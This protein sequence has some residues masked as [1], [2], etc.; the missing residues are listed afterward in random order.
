MSRSMSRLGAAMLIGSEAMVPFRYKDSVG[1]D[2]EGIGHTV[3]A[4]APDPA[5][6]PFGQEIPLEEV[7]RTFRRDLRKF[8]KRVNDAV[9]VSIEQHEFDAVTH[10]DFNTGGVHRARLT[11]E[12]NAGR[13]AAA[14]A[15]FGGWHRPPEIIPRRNAEKRLFR[16]GTYAHGGMATVYPA[17]DLGR[18]QWGQG[19]RIDVMP[20]VDQ[21]FAANE[22]EKAAASDVRK[23]GVSSVG[24]AASGTG[25]GNVAPDPLA[26]ADPAFLKWLLIGLAV[27]LVVAAVAYGFRA[28]RRWLSARR[29]DREAGEELGVRIDAGA[30]VDPREPEPFLGKAR[31]GE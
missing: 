9:T 25:G 8:E 15:A 26:A 18:V 22:D 2:T 24:G 29:R 31:E 6:R 14:A 16:D 23:A 13:M 28:V 21:V 3:G 30:P 5:N 12:I 27:V 4:G 19:R 7:L 17:D 20:I 11:R 10:F 1:E